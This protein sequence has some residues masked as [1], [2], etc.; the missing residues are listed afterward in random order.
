MFESAELGHKLS[1]EAYAQ[2]EPQLRTDLLNAQFELLDVR[3]FATV[4]LINGVD[5]AG[6]GETVNL[7]NAWM[8][9]RHIEVHAFDQ[10][11]DEARERPFMWRFWRA[12]PPK[13]K[14]GILFGNWYS[15]AIGERSNR[16]IKKAQLDQRLS[17]FNRFEA[18]LAAEGVLLIKLWFHLSQDGQKKRLKALEANPATRWRVRDADWELYEQYGRYREVAEHVL[19]RTSTGLAPWVIV[20][21]SDPQYRAVF[22]GRTLLDQLQHRIELARK[23][24]RARQMAAP[25]LPAQDSRNLLNALVLDQPLD[26][27]EYERELERLQGRLALAVRGEAFA[28]RSL[29]LV[30][31]GMDAAGKGGAIRRVTAALDT[32]QYHVVPIAAPTDEESAQPYLWR[33]WRRLP[34]RGKLTLFD[35]SWYGRVLVE[36]VEGFCSEADWM[37]AYA[38]INDFE[39]Q[40]V[41]AGTIVVKFWLSVSDAEQLRRFHARE[42]EA[43]KRY[44]ITPDDWRNREKWPLYEP[45]ICDMIDRTSTENAAWT[46]VEADNKY[47]ARVKILRVLVD[48]LESALKS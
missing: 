11:T 5:G 29:V 36:R 40:L 15:D 13:G 14:I 30:F 22:V 9:P 26:K 27:K 31:E 41:S 10:P 19:R 42:E 4:I 1:K 16:R 45:A 12:L 3:D 47:Y 35:R 32:R 43:F 21:G 33:F 25:L 23:G 28:K 39:D 44:K 46:L 24:F 34:R 8:D 7:L 6:R 20:D 18:M 37:R 17:E 48:K 38:E 2:I